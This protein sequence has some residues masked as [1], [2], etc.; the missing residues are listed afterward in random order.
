MKLARIS[1]REAI[2]CL[3][4][5]ML[6]PLFPR[7][8]NADV[9]DKVIIQVG[10]PS[11]W[12]LGQAHYLLAQIQKR[13]RDL[14][15][16]MPKADDLDPNGINATRIQI[17][18]TLLDVGAEFSQKVGVE[19]Q[20]TLQEHKDKLK[21]RDEAR[22]ELKK[23][24]EE[25]DQVKADLAKLNKRQ[26]TVSAEL[27]QKKTERERV[28]PNPNPP[29]D[30][31]LT[32]PPDKAEN[33]LETAKA[34][35]A[36][37]IQ[38]KKDQQ[39]ALETDVKDLKAEADND[40]SLSGLTEVTPNNSNA[41]LPQM[42]SFIQDAIKRTA[43]AMGRPRFAASIALDNYIG[44]QYEILAKQL[45]LL[46]DE[47]GPDKRVIFLELPSSIYTPACKG[48]E[49][50]AQVQWKVSGFLRQDDDDEAL[51]D[52]EKNIR[53]RIRYNK[54]PSNQNPAPKQ[55]K[56]DES[57]TGQNVQFTLNQ[58]LGAEEES[59]WT[60][61]GANDVRA[62]DII[63]RQSALNVNDVQ[64][65]ISQKN[66]LG[67]LKLLMGFGL[68][69]NY[70][71]QQEL[72]EQYLQQEVFAS[73]FG[74]GLNVFGWTFGPLPGTS[75]IAPGVRT[76]YAVLA[77][78]RGTTK[79]QIEAKG[80]A[81]HRKDAPDYAD[82]D[83]VAAGDVN[84]KQV[85]FKQ[86]FVVGIPGENTE[87]FFVDSM[88]Y[89]PARKGEAVTVVVKGRNFSPQMSTLVDGVAL[90]RS[91][92]LGNTATSDAVKDTETTGIHGQFELVS[93]RELVMKFSMGDG[94]VGTPNLTLVTPEKS[95][96]LNFLDLLINNHRPNTMLRDLV[97]TEPM[98]MPDLK[99]P[100][101][102]VGLQ[103]VSGTGHSIARLKGVGLRR[104]ADIWINDTHLEVVREQ[105]RKMELITR[106]TPGH[107]NSSEDLMQL[108]FRYANERAD[109]A[110][111]A[112]I[113]APCTRDDRASYVRFWLNYLTS[114]DELYR[115][116][117]EHEIERLKTPAGGGKTQ[118][119]AEDEVKNK[120]ETPQGIDEYA[121]EES[122]GQYS[123]RFKTVANGRYNVRYRQNT[124]HGFDEAEFVHQDPKK[125]NQA[126]VMHYAPNAKASKA[127]LDVR[128]KAQKAVECAKIS[129]DSQGKLLKDQFTLE[130]ENQ[131]RGVF[132]VDYDD[133][134]SGK[135]EK[136]KVSISLFS[137][138]CKQ[139]KK[140]IETLDI[141][142]PVRPQVA[143]ATLTLLTQDGESKP[144]ITL[145]GVNLQ[146]IVKV[147]VGD[148][149][150]DIIGAPDNGILVVKLPKGMSIKEDAAV[151]VPVVLKT[152][153]GTQVSVVA[154]VGDP[155]P[156][157]ST[158]TP[159]ARHAKGKQHKQEAANSAASVQQKN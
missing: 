119:D 98:F 87:R 134:G 54:A 53:A 59:T 143:K 157:S 121:I 96:A 101:E 110:C 40:V 131:Y 122:T 15:T 5:C 29:P 39:T 23:K 7:L 79:L 22:A 43:D 116:V 70:Q 3:L 112:R 37:K 52:N 12:S 115:V 4:V 126:T 69:V 128:F 73:G 89:T 71:R 156:V 117:R 133:L 28:K 149:E 27:L 97:V 14:N 17:L 94:Y 8:T 81:F 16:N 9:K 113:G 57:A 147:L 151:Q 50:I 78:P 86:D 2:S 61:A 24:Q 19:N 51:T 46:R 58:A 106:H 139:A 33:D 82:R 42:S 118:Q 103:D 127:I 47:A 35:L 85:V 74:K 125:T 56:N 36:A 152:N 72:Y 91:L 132:V 99:L 105:S 123:L 90:T 129:P 20:A 80:V 120:Y 124:I 102:L 114:F 45:T 107:T 142:L 95:S 67:V 108:R 148:K 65:T 140:I 155:K 83:A 49:Y 25:L 153:D 64:S 55:S 41:T 100:E 88:Y 63:P 150:A 145:E 75:R 60:P 111:L 76:T 62:V 38:S 130:G 44:M 21:R 66:F 13:N 1:G 30:N 11:V 138:S 6:L 68:K 144:V 93:S 146:T 32:A 18:R 10:A 154:T 158:S 34:D 48:D 136:T 135:V 159:V 84:E 26:A 104:K 92:S 109:A 141:T 77:I 31:L 137:D